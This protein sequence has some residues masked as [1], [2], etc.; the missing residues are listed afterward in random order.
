MRITKSVTVLLLLALLVGMLSGCATE[1]N[2]DLLDSVPPLNTSKE[3]ST[4][5]V[6]EDPTPAEGQ[7]AM[8]KV[9]QSYNISQTQVLLAGTCEEN[10]VINASAIGGGKAEVTANGT[11]FAVVVYV[12]EL[13]STNIQLTATAEGKTV[14]ETRVVPAGYV[15]S[16]AGNAVYPTV[17]YDNV[18]LFLQKTLDASGSSVIRTNTALNTFKKL[19]NSYVYT[20]NTK[21]YETEIIYVLIPSKL[22][23]MPELAG[24]DETAE[25]ARVTLYSQAKEVLEASDATVIDLTEALKNAQE[26][27]PTYYRTYSLWS[28]YAAYVG[29]CEVM[30]Y[31]AEKYPDAAPRALDEFDIKKVE[32]LG[33]DLAYHIGL[34]RELFTETVYDFVPKFDTAIGDKAP[35]SDDEEDVKTHLI[36]EIQQY[37]N[38]EGGNYLPCSSYFAGKE[39]VPITATRA[40]E[41]FGFY[42]GRDN[43]PTALIYRD[44]YSIPMV[45]MLAERF[46]NSVFM[47]GGVFNIN[48]NKGAAYSAEGKDNVDYIIVFA[49][50]ENLTKLIAE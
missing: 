8:P 9:V 44:E 23:V 50:E 29:Y 25:A 3:E 13:E 2:T 19:V 14:S 21:N 24:I 30:N 10:A 42:T 31:I 34:D 5:A 37:I 47:A 45:D 27:Y 41:E 33:G 12:G 40:D 11:T 17:L 4:E 26:D 46:N 39:L 1:G 6:V 49:S 32:A 20:I 38:A 22:T 35:A 18:S 15:A 7:T 28:E 43:L 16:E 36:S 48:V